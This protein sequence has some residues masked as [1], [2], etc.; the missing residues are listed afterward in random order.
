MAT[1]HP[2]PQVVSGSLT[3][4]KDFAEIPEGSAARAE[5]ESAFKD[6]LASSLASTGLGISAGDIEA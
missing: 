1:L 4:D 6:S 3:F 2:P 5:F